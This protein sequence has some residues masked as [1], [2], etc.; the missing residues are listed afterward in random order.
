MRLLDQSL[1]QLAGISPMAEIALRNK[2]I[3]TGRQLVTQAETLFSPRQAA[4]IREAYSR[5]ELA[6]E[7]G[8]LDLL[9]NSMPCGHRVRVLADYL[10]QALF[11]DVETTGLSSNAQIVC[12]STCLNGKISSFV[13]GRNL[14][15]FLLQWSQAG[16]LVTFNGKHFDMPLVQREFS[17]SAVPAHID[18]RDEARTFG[19]VV[20]LKS[21]E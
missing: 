4:K 18:L 19:Y 10:S 2:G 9:V 12:I 15:Q 20:G 5:I 14:E 8:L 1:C 3:W 7:N 16:M 13:R 6:R 17:L 21:I 11:L